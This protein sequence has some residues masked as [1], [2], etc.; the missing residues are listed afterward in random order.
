MTLFK[1]Q[2]F[3]IA[4]RINQAESSASHAQSEARTWELRCKA[5]EKRAQ[6]NYE[7]W[8]TAEQEINRLRRMILQLSYSG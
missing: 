4:S 6:A 2:P 5:A 8:E 1:D 3:V 7:K